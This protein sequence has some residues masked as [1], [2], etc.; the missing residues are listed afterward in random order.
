MVAAYDAARQN[1]RLE[2]DSRPW[3]IVTTLFRAMGKS[4][5]S[6]R[7]R[8]SHE[9][10]RELLDWASATELEAEKRSGLESIGY[11][12]WPPFLIEIS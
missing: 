8:I 6:G 10:K 1:E 11:A 5:A 9:L 2:V 7:S 3:L 4:F 12:E